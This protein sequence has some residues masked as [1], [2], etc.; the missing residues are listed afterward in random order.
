MSD[1]SEGTRFL[2]MAIAWVGIFA[3][4]ITLF[5][6]TGSF[7]LGVA[8]FIVEVLFFSEFD[9]ITAK[10]KIEVNEAT[11]QLIVAIVLWIPTLLM[12]C[13]NTRFMRMLK[14]RGLHGLFRKR[15]R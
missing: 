5:F 8:V 14:V 7:G 13:G 3:L 6:K 9:L 2:I 11:F 10:M 1:L 12:W 4:P 15:R